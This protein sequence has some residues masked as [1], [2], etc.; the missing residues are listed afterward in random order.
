MH[1]RILGVPDS[2]SARRKCFDNPG[3]TSTVHCFP[4]LD[5]VDFNDGQAVYLEAIASAE[6][7]AIENIKN[8]NHSPAKAVGLI[9]AWKVD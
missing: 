9:N 8:I 3:A 4:W 5:T 7:I 1:L 6:G 2:I